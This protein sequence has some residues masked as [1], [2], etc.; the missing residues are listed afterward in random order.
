[1]DQIEVADLFNRL[2]FWSALPSLVQDVTLRTILLFIALL[3][4]WVIRD[5]VT[6]ILM[7]PVRRLSR[8]TEGSIDNQLVEAVQRPLRI[9]ILGIA[10]I[11]ISTLLSFGTDVDNFVDTFAR[12]II[13]AA[14]TMFIYN[15][16]DVIA[17]N[18]ENV[19]QVTGLTIADRLLPFTR[20]VVKLFVLV[21]GTLTIF[22]EFG[23]DATGLIASFGVIGLAFSLAAQDTA[24]N[25]F[26][27]TAIVSDNPFE[28]GDYIVAS[29][30]AGTVERVGV[31]STR[32]RKLDQ[33]LVTVPNNALTNASVTNWSRLRK[34]RLDYYI[35]VTY[36]TTSQQMRELLQQLRDM[37][38]ERENIDPS[39]VVV[40]FVE[41]G[42]SALQIR[43]IAYILIADWTLYT[44]EVEQINLEIMEIVEGMG[45]SMAF[46]S[47]SLYVEQ[48]PQPIQPTP[49]TTPETS[50]IPTPDN[51]PTPVRAEPNAEPSY[52]DNNTASNGD[53]GG[54]GDG[55]DG[56]R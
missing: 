38:M 16:V 39:S 35:G 12:A 22:N 43:V 50:S 32:V 37:L 42:D 29:D 3:A 31:R 17:V 14:V 45:L 15:L 36:S 19:Q 53:E 55:G 41:F 20:T 34:R 30:F 21:L 2:P 6:R 44:A 27:F 25:V 7:L 4:I 13:V 18:S 48:W 23:F 52:Q 46:P 40:H 47:R 10:L 11:L 1:M 24:A 54:E 26:G 49:T 56:G 9:A 33:S 51:T 28:V 8:R 5:L